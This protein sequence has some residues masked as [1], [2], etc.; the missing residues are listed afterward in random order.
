M[1]AG[2]WHQLSLAE[3]MGNIGSAFHRWRNTRSEKSFEELLNLTDLTIVDARW[4][5]RLSEL[6]RLRE[7]VCD[8]NAGS[9]LYAVDP[10]ILD[11]YFLPF[12]M[13][14]RK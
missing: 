13:L 5:T 10:D 8:L 2:R 6:T 9:Q 11:N 1:E 12:A 3:Q 7:V 4:T 14:V